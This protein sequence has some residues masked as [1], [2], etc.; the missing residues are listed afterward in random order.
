MEELIQKLKRVGVLK[1]KKIAEALRAAPRELFVPDSLKNL[2]YEDDAL[3]ISHGQTISQPYTVVFMLELLEVEEG[4]IILEAGYGSGWQ[5]ALLAYLAGE[6]GKVYAFEIVPKLCKFGEENLTR[7][8][9]L[10]SRVIKFCQSA[11]AGLPEL[12]GKIDRIIAAAEVSKIP[13][14]WQE[15]LKIGGIMIYPSAGSIWRERKIAPDKFS[16]ENFP[17]FVFVPYV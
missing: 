17:G 2:A 6:K 11:T 9:H 7:I 16:R 4:Q 15:Q 12:A 10:N 5:T 13:E 3:P 14:S 1:S 8:P